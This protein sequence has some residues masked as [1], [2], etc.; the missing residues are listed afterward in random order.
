MEG[1]ESQLKSI[2]GKWWEPNRKW[3]YPAWLLYETTV[4]FYDYAFSAY[5]FFIN[6]QD[7]IGEVAA[8]ALSILGSLG[9]FV[10][11]FAFLTI[12]ASLALF[13]FFKPEGTGNSSFEIEI[14][15]YF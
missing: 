11:C 4:H 3:F 8:Q 10:I 15:K 5:Q 12:P 1:K 13:K 14:K 9:T 2:W 6:Q 7:G